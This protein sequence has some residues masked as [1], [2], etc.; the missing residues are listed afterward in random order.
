MIF[1]IEKA[2]GHAETIEA[3]RM[4][5]DG[6]VIRFLA[7]DGRVVAVYRSA[8]VAEVKEQKDG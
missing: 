6:A 2:S 5:R 8:H 7:A 3:D 4:E 1:R